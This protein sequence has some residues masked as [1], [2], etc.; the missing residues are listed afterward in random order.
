MREKSFWHSDKKNLTNLVFNFYD[1]IAE[2][3]VFVK[4]NTLCFDLIVFISVL[5]PCQQDTS[6]EEYKVSKQEEATAYF[7]KYSQLNNKQKFNFWN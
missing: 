6:R 1:L 4:S 2:T 3:I 5:H 7:Q